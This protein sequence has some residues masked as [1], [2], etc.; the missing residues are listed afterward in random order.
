MDFRDRLAMF[1]NGFPDHEIN[2]RTMKITFKLSADELG[3]E[4]FAEFEEPHDKEFTLGFTWEVCGSCDGKGSYVNPS[5]DAHGITE[6]EMEEWDY[7]EE[8]R[9][10]SGGYDVT[11]EECKGRRVS[12]KVTND[13]S[14]GY[15][16][17]CS[18]IENHAEL[19][20][21]REHEIRYGY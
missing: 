20:R 17:W 3:D 14:P 21:E 18:A 8:E 12:P 16:L 9:Y 11:C 13:N 7:D 15:R 2:D 5:I 1:G 19:V 4:E 10:F 6:S